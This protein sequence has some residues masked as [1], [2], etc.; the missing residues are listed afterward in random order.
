[1]TASKHERD[2]LASGSRREPLSLQPVENGAS[3]PDVDPDSRN[4]EPRSPSG[5]HRAGPRNNAQG[6]QNGNAG[7][8]PVSER[9][10]QPRPPQ[11]RSGDQDSVEPPSAGAEAEAEQPTNGAGATT[12]D[13]NILDPAAADATA[14]DETPAADGTTADPTTV[15]QPPVDRP[16][17]KGRPVATL[18]PS[19]RAAAR[20]SE[21]QTTV[22]AAVSGEPATT[23]TKPDD[24][25]A[26]SDGPKKPSKPAKKGSFWKELPILIGV[27]LVLTFLIQNFIARVYVIPS[28]SMELTLNGCPGC[29]GDRILV[30]KM[31]YRFGPPQPG[32]VVVFKGPPGWDQSEFTA[33]SSSNPVVQW[34]REFGS[35]IGIGSPPEY[36]LVKRVIAVGGQTISCC[37]PKNR[38]IVDG[39][40]LNE[41]YAYLNGQP[42]MT[43]G[44]VKIPNGYLWVMGD[45]RNNSDDSRL[46][47]GAQNDP[48]RGIV[49]AS[50][51]IGIARTIIWPPS[52][53]RGIGEINPHKTTVASAPA[54]TEGLPAGVGFAA[55]W[56]T[57]WMGRRLRRRMRG[58]AAQ[59]VAP[60]HATARRRR[61]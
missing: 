23:V 38:T 31:S 58:A 61:R 32:D 21:D 6:G 57:L 28:G 24:Q 29:V 48:I 43:F 49:P 33:A 18:S 11:H 2:D 9:N 20:Q 17:G 8:V 40:P 4:S 47:N 37:D 34:L 27:A 30:D 16:V 45:N 25:E 10:V 39:K 5:K 51:V 14:A 41:P 46:Q 3:W 1:M 36:D 55:A 50:N 19:E 60:A 59:G 13:P 15:D 44:P 56:P 52:R 22:M 35:S 53:W 54:W 26:S 7:W 12:I 42:Q